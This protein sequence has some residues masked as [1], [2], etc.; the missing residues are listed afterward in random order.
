MNNRIT[1]KDIDRVVELIAQEMGVPFGHYAVVSSLNPLPDHVRV[2][3]ESSDYSLLCTIPNGLDVDYASCYGGYVIEQMTDHVDENGKPGTGNSHPFG[4]QR[5]T[6]RHA[7]DV[8]HGILAGI[9]AGKRVA[10]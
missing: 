4:P 5:Y 9:R 8:F 3:R 6:G 1:R 2:L 10:Q 7:F